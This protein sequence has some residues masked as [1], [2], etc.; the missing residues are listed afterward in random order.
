MRYLQGG[1]EEEWGPTVWKRETFVLWLLHAC[2]DA[3]L[4]EMK[5]QLTTI[6]VRYVFYVVFDVVI[7]KRV[8]SIYVA[9]LTWFWLSNVWKVNVSNIICGA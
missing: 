5:N 2:N 9:L 4:M 8:W 7:A 6:A 1:V 3:W